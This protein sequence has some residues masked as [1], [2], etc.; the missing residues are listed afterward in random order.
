MLER[1]RHLSNREFARKAWQAWEIKD[2][3]QW[4]DSRG[5]LSENSQDNEVP[6]FYKIKL[7]M[8]RQL[9][10]VGLVWAAA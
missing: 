1:R 5:S 9:G 2:N 8:R 10:L 6:E 4:L 7:I 3:D